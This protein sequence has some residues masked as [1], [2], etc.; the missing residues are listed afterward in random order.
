M[1]VFDLLLKHCLELYRFDIMTKDIL[2]TFMVGL[3]VHV[4]VILC[5]ACNA[6]DT[7]Q[8]FHIWPHVHSCLL[9]L[10]VY[11]FFMCLQKVS[12]CELAPACKCQSVCVW[13]LCVTLV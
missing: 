11:V 1:S 5:M 4:Y 6:L 9:R 12:Q 10:G 2:F 13:G 8:C 3:L 7:W